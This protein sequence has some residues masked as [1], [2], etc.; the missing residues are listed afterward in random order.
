MKSFSSSTSN[1]ASD[2]AHWLISFE[3]MV[4]MFCCRV[5][6]FFLFVLVFDGAGTADLVEEDGFF[7]FFLR[8]F[9]RA[10]FAACGADDGCAFAVCGAADRLGAADRCGAAGF[11]G[12]RDAE[13]ALVGVGRG[14]D[15]GWRTNT[16]TSCVVATG[17]NAPAAAQRTTVA[18]SGLRLGAFLAGES[19]PRHGVAW[20]TAG[21]FRHVAASR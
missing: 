15:A 11:R 9:V 1:V 19:A 14:G 16:E 5:V 4:E 17:L 3:M 12:D 7:F 8:L 21:R 18:A 20:R 10:A 2:R 13:L 6:I